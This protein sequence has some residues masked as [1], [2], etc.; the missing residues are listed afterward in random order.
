MMGI[1]LQ[2]YEEA[3]RI[4][5]PCIAPIAIL[6]L[7][8]RLDTPKSPGGFLRRLTQRARSGELDMKRWLASS[9]II[10]S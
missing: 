7:L 5:A 8:D 2:T 1:D 3:S 6:C 4:M 10:V 9:G